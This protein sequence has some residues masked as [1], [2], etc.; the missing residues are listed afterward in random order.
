MYLSMYISIYLSTYLSI[1]LS[2][3]L[4]KNK[5]IRNDTRNDV[6]TLW[7]QKGVYK[8]RRSTSCVSKNVI[9]ITFCL[10]CLKQEVGSTVD[11]KPILRNNKSHIKQKVPACS[12]VNRFIDVCSGRDDPSGNTRFIIINQLSNTN[13]LSPDD[14]DN[15]LLQKERFC[16][17][18]YSRHDRIENVVQ[19]T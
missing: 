1:Y 2:I 18:T 5:Y 7:S 4:S 3:Y 15:L 17:S 10:N 19:N 12:I 16:I 8:F 6:R 11:W 9:Y 13:S 14:I